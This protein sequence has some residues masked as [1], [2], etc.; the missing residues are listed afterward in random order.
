MSAPVR[1]VGKDA[2]SPM[3]TIL[4]FLSQ[5]T[6][7]NW[8]RSFM[9]NRFFLDAKPTTENVTLEG[10]Q[11]HHAVQV[12]RLTT[13]DQIILFDGTGVEYHA[14]IDQVAKKRL[15]LRILNTIAIDRAVKTR[16]TLAIAMPKGDRQRFLIE[17]LVELGVE[18][19]VPLKTTRSVAVAN[20]KVIK[21]LKKQVTEASKQCRRNR[22]MEIDDE[23]TLA[24]FSDSLDS[25]VTK[26]IAD[27]YRGR[28]ISQ[29]IGTGSGKNSN[30]VA[31]AIGPEGG[32]DDQENELAQSLGFQPVRLG[33]A[34][35]RV[36]TA[37]VAVAAIFGIGNEVEPVA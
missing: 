23:K 5:R 7:S 13:G 36:E 29:W 25:S 11:A 27:P 20:E 15:S 6:R 8:R 14:V 4:T 18:R 33:P 34:I 12:M 1:I 9:S 21:R 26:L 28:P 22:L 3:G 37:A 31:V 24:Q 2:C 32:F 16:I 30:P 10:D 35:L 19:L 17:K